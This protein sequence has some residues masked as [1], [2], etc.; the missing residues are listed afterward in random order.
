VN[1]VLIAGLPVKFVMSSNILDA[2]EPSDRIETTI[3]RHT[4]VTDLTFNF[5]DR[6]K[7]MHVYICICENNL[8]IN[9]LP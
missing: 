7:Y 1:C 5:Y 2:V 8:F 9:I 4:N 3:T 6:Y